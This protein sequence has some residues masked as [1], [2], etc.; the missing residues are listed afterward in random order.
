MDKIEIILHPVRFR[1]IQCFLDGEEK[2]AKIIANELNDIAQ[3][4]LYRQLDILVKGRILLITEENQIR[5]TVEK[6][7]SL[8]TSETVL[9]NADLKDLTKEEHLQYFLL[10]TAQLAK[11]F[12][13]YLQKDPIDFD[14]DGVG[15][16]QIALHLSDQEFIKFAGEMG[17]VVEKYRN[18]TPAPNRT[19]RMISSVVIP[20]YE[21]SKGH[22]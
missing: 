15:Y 18:H 8:N 5:G 20:K 12:E 3:A 22:E 19:K 6:V 14:K 9:S 16:R 2:T 21:G 4:T 11:H 17:N 1:I 10:F 7:Y 13:S